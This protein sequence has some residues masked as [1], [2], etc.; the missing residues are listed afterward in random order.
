[1]HL[2]MY[3]IYIKFANINND[4]ISEDVNETNKLNTYVCMNN[5]NSRKIF[6]TWPQDLKINI[7]INKIFFIEN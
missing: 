7:T 5:V 2:N 3:D 4:K 6:K 1:M